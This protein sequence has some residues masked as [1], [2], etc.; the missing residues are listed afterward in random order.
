MGEPEKLGRYHVV[1]YLASGGMAEILLGKM[2]GP[3]GFERPVVIKRILPHHAKKEAFVD[4]F[5]DEAR[6]V[7]RIQHPNVVHVQELGK[8]NDQLFM[9]MEY[10][11]GESLLS[12]M[13]R[14][15]RIGKPVDPMLA[16][17]IVSQA[18]A[19]LHAAHE[20]CDDQGKPLGL[21][22]RDVSPSNIFITY[23]GAVK[24][25]DFGIAKFEQRTTDTEAGALKGKFPYMSPEQCHGKILDRRSDIFSLG[26]VLWETTL[27]RRLF[28]RDS[29][30]K[31][32]KAITEDVIPS[33]R[34]VVPSYPE[35]LAAVCMKALNRA[36]AERYATAADMQLALIDVTRNHGLAPL[37]AMALADLMLEFFPERMEQKRELLRRVKSG[38]QITHVPEPDVDV[39]VEVPTAFSSV[40]SLGSSTPMA[41]ESQ[42]M[43]APTRRS[44]AP[45]I[46]ALVAVMLVA[47]GAAWWAS[48]DAAPTSAAASGS[49]RDS[50]ADPDPAPG[51]VADP[52]DSVADADPDPD[53]VADPDPDPDPGSEA[54]SESESESVELT[55]RSSPAAE[56]LIDG[57]SVGHTPLTLRV[58]R[59]SVSSRVEFRAPGHVPETRLWV[60]FRDDALEVELRARRRRADMR[61]SPMA[62]EANDD[63]TGSPFRRFN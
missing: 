3:S 7:A 53:P 6:V 56:V 63:M 42:A 31:S 16:A 1:G 60:P 29:S 13:R 48:G 62:M 11:E 49:V 9:V 22:H 26:T 55:L 32:M 2:L 57:E 43:P 46:A 17:W 4:M 34:S 61:D 59:A 20:L 8:E 58:D 52:A 14:A 36:R 21:V 25:L 27:G 30:F 51:S 18:C 5:L 44:K 54:E 35:D 33:P 45:M 15:V 50:V 10:L 40:G 39:S 19:G 28:A 12:L 47:A 37:P 23:A 41:V 38:S 24:L